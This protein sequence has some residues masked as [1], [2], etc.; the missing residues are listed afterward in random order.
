[1][2][3]TDKSGIRFKYE[4]PV[5]EEISIVPRDEFM[6][7]KQVL[8]GSSPISEAERLGIPNE[9]PLVNT[10]AFRSSSIAKQNKFWKEVKN[11]IN[12]ENPKIKLKV[13]DQ[14][15]VKEIEDELSSIFAKKMKKDLPVNMA[16]TSSGDIIIIPGNK[17][18]IARTLYGLENKNITLDNGQIVRAHAKDLNNGSGSSPI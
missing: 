4:S 11:R 15:N 9:L 10:D 1:M 6:A 16:T 7:T 14:Q 8:P 2:F 17:E 3:A 18:E 13:Q 12:P 5:T